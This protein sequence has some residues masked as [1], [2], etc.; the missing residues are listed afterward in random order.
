MLKIGLDFDNTIT[1]SLE[2]LRFFQMLTKTFKGQAEIHIITGR[3]VI[4]KSRKETIEELKLLDIHYDHL[5]MTWDKRQ[6]IIKNK[7]EIYFDDMDEFIVDL[8]KSVTVFKVRENWNFNF[9]SQQWLYSDKTG[10][11]LKG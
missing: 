8:P 9:T 10:T 3:E 7:I 6:Y 11:K 1:A 2:S 5:E 4:G